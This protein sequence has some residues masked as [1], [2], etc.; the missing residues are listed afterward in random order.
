MSLLRVQGRGNLFASEPQG[1]AVE[2]YYDVFESGTMLEI[3][4]KIMS[5]DFHTL[6]S[7]FQGQTR[8]TLKTDTFS[9]QL[10][11]LDENGHF[12]ATGGPIYHKK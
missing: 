12:K 3:E 9:L 10:Y 7:W 11:I 5:D 1:L 8:L 2:F 6:F 4:G